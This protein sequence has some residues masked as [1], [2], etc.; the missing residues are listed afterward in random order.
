[1]A[2]L[3]AARSLGFRWLSSFVLTPHQP[4]RQ[5]CSRRISAGRAPAL[6]GFTICARLRKSAAK[7]F[8]S[9]MSAITVLLGFYF[10]LFGNSGDFG[11]S[12]A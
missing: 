2:L 3:Q 12:R 7:R 1:M 11:N 10:S 9:N 4:R 5:A 6:P 8:S